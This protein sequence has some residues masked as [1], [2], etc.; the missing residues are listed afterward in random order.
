[1]MGVELIYRG[2]DMS[3]GRF[4]FALGDARIEVSATIE[5][6]VIQLASLQVQ[7]SPV[8]SD[9]LRA[10][11]V[12]DIRRIIRDQLRDS[13]GALL[14]GRAL[15]AG[16]LRGSG[17]EVPEHLAL[18]EKRAAAAVESLRS[19]D[20]MGP[21]PTPDDYHRQ[22]SLGLIGAF[23]QD[24]QRPVALLAKQLDAPRSTVAD[25]VRRARAAG[26]LAETTPGRAGAEPGPKLIEWLEG[27]TE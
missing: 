9:L 14:D 13:G 4:Q 23:D 19:R 17:R 27:E 11:H 12:A 1:M 16:F 18:A 15:L 5:R 7:A 26:W 22:I 24:P 2:V 21:R 20:P 10:I 6:G 3:S 25:R 8:K